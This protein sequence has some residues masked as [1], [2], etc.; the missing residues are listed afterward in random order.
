MLECAFLYTLPY[1]PEMLLITITSKIRYISIERGM[2]KKQMS[3]VVSTIY[4]KEM[5]REGYMVTE[6]K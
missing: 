3:V 1:T 4:V 5:K 2:R 6:V